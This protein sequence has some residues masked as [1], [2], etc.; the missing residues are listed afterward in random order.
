MK[1][2]RLP[3]TINTRRAYGFMAA[4]FLIGIAMGLNTYP[5]LQNPALVAW[6]ALGLGILVQLFAIVRFPG[7]KK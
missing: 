7:N 4:A 3:E 5:A 2:T 1:N 6:I